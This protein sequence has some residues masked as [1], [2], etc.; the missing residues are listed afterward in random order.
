MYRLFLVICFSLFQVVT[1]TG[2]D[3]VLVASDSAYDAFILNHEPLTAEELSAFK[4]DRT[5]KTAYDAYVSAYL[6]D[7]TTYALTKNAIQAAVTKRTRVNLEW[8]FYS[9]AALFLLL[10]LVRNIWREYFDKVFLVYFNQ[11]FILRQ[12]KDA[13]MMWSLPS[14]LLNIL[15]VLSAGFFVFFGQGSNYLLTGMDRWQVMSFIM[16][17]IAFVYLFKYFFLKFLGWMFNQKEVF[18]QYSFMVFLNNKIVGVIMLVASFVM[19]FSG[20]GV[21][22]E[23]F[24]LVLYLIGLLFLIRVVNAFRIFSLQTKAGIFNILLAF[25]SVEILPTA[26]L[27]KFSL[28]SILLLTEGVL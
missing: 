3:S 25:I 22:G 21:Y 12:K 10:G 5:H 17:I 8:V 18:E 16:I 28:H 19:A 9:F 27:V 2:Q 7:H 15:F 13:M 23:I 24:S 1:T 14:V 4:L 20:K 6:Q 26:M 11:G